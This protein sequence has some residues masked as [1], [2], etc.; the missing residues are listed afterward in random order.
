MH[1]RITNERCFK[2]VVI[3][4]GQSIEDLECIMNMKMIIVWLYGE[5]IRSE[6]DSLL[7]TRFLKWQHTL[8]I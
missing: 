7:A 1:N 5:T 6:E 2:F 8:I 4:R 3:S